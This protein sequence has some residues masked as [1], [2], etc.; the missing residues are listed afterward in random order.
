[1]KAAHSCR[2]PS[3]ALGVTRDASLA[4]PQRGFGSLVARPP[5]SLAGRSGHRARSASARA[6]RVTPMQG[7]LARDLMI[8]Y[9]GFRPKDYG[10][11]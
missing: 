8:H 4:S 11:A 1:M 3:L 5:S 6:L 2:A 9:T 10:N 7:T